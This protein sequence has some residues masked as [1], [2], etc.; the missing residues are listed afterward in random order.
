MLGLAA[1]LWIVNQDPEPPRWSFLPDA[2]KGVTIDSRGKIWCEEGK[3]SVRIEEVRA[4]IKDVFEGKTAALRGA[5]ISLVDRAGTLWV[6]PHEEADLLLGFDGKT[7]F[8]R[9]VRDTARTWQGSSAEALVFHPRAFEDSQGN[10]WFPD[11]DGVHRRDSK[12]AWEYFPL[13][14]KPGEATNGFRNPEWAE[15]PGGAIYAWSRG[16]GSTPGTPGFF[17]FDGASFVLFEGRGCGHVCPLA[18]GGLI[19]DGRRRWLR[20]EDLK[21]AVDR[22]AKRMK[23]DD[24]DERER[25]TQDLRALGVE[26][27]PAVTALLK[28]GHD[29]DLDARLR[30]VL[31]G[32]KREP[33]SQ[34]VGTIKFASAQFLVKTRKG[35][36]LFK[37]WNCKDASTDAATASRLMSLGADGTCT[38]GPLPWP[39]GTPTPGRLFEDS[40]GRLWSGRD[41]IEGD[42]LVRVIPEDFARFSIIVGEDAKGRLILSTDGV[43][44]FAVYDESA[45][46]PPALKI[47]SWALGTYACAIEAD[48][49][50]WAVLKEA[51]TE[52]S[53]FRD[54]K[55]ESPGG[56]RTDEVQTL[57]ALKGGALLAFGNKRSGFFDGTRWTCFNNAR[58]LVA[59]NLERLRTAASGIRGSRIAVDDLGGI[60]LAH[61]YVVDRFDGKDWK[62][63]YR[64]HYRSI[65]A[66]D[67]GKFVYIGEP[68]SRVQSCV[69]RWKD[70]KLESTPID[71]KQHI[72]GDLSPLVDAEGALWLPKGRSAAG[73]RIQGGKRDTIEGS[74]NP[75]LLDSKKRTW[76][77][78][79]VARKVRVKDGDRWASV[80]LE[81]VDEFSRMA[82][83]PDGRIWLVHAKGL[84]LME[85]TGDGPVEKSRWV[86]GTPK[87]S[88]FKGVFCDAAGS[89]WIV[90][91]GGLIRVPQP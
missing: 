69:A 38:I 72:P 53:R 58:E 80:T 57:V 31:D 30:L 59:G 34:Y 26:S 44:Y 33:D 28:D 90:G 32:F 45:K 4:S 27:T 47:E 35:P 41:R 86:Q 20:P 25:A 65:V 51:P 15:G 1:C 13:L 67:G 18:D 52:P 3:A 91:S 81:G 79:E 64:V 36:A 46:E 66:F 63:I 29:A 68:Q 71:R 62:E 42:K 49:V 89:L 75:L 12:G 11:R 56:E 84:S 16:G 83:S 24:G 6:I 40:K 88:S 19:V 2:V 17:R 10:A 22:L 48:G 8:E 87:A 74:G 76:F 50:V 5:K 82:E 78:D 9:R 37:L 55:W 14:H 73:L 60:W 7:W 21:A 61:G 43:P 39:E 85:A 77:F 23:S 70:G 54:G